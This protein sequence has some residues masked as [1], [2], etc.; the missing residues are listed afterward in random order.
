MPFAEMKSRFGDYKS[1]KGGEIYEY[2]PYNL[3][4]AERL[5][6]PGPIAM[7][8]TA[9]MVPSLF[10][11]FLINTTKVRPRSDSAGLCPA[12]VGVCHRASTSARAR[13]DNAASGNTFPARRL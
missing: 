2:G 3:K 9:I 8:C 10:P 5:C 1:F 4:Q 6:V 11:T 12:S 7:R 13:K